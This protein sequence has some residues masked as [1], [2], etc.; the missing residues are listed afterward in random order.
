M[1]KLLFILIIFVM[2]IPVCVRAEGETVVINSITLEEKTGRAVEFADPSVDGLT[3]NYDVRFKDVNDSVK[4]VINITNNDNESLFIRDNINSVG[5]NIKYEIDF[6]ED[7]LLPG[8][9]RDIVLKIT[10]DKKVNNSDFKGGLYRNNN[11]IKLSLKDKQTLLLEVSNTLADSVVKPVLMV[12]AVVLIVFMINIIWKNKKANTLLILF[13]LLLIPKETGALKTFVIDINNKVA[14]EFKPC[15]TETNTLR[16]GQYLY[17]NSSSGWSVILYDKGLTDPVTTPLCSSVND[18]PITSMAY[19]FGESKTTSVDTST[20]DTSH[21]KTMY[22]MFYK[23]ANIE[24][25]DLSTFDTSNVTDMNSMFDQMTNV[26]SINIDSFDTRNVTSFVNMFRFNS[27]L[28]ELDTS[29]IVVSKPAS[30]AYVYAYDTKLKKIDL[31]N[32]DIKIQNS[33]PFGVMAGATGVE[34]VDMSNWDLSGKSAMNLLG[35]VLGGSSYSLNG[36]DYG[37]TFIIKKVILKN[38]NFSNVDMSY[39]FGYAPSIEEFDLENVN[40]TGVTNMNGL[41]SGDK[42]LKSIDLSSFDVSEVTNMSYM[43]DSN[44]ALKNIDLSGLNP[45]KV[46][47]MY[48]MFMK[49]TSLEN[50]NLSNFEAPLLTDMGYFLYGSSAIE[51]VDLSS[52]KPNAIHAM[53]N[54][55]NGA[56]SVKKLNISNFNF[57]DYGYSNTNILGNMAAPQTLEELYMENS[58]LTKLSFTSFTYNYKSLTKVS[59]KNSD[60]T[61]ITNFTNFMSYIPTLTSLDI[62]GVKT[63]D[64]TDFTMAFSQLENLEELDVSDLDTDSATTFYNMFFGNFKIKEYDVSK[65]KTS[66]VT[67]LYGMFSNNYLLESMDFSG[68]N[69]SSLGTAQWILG[70]C[71]KLKSVSFKGWDF[72]RIEDYDMF[73]RIIGGSSYALSTSSYPELK[74]LDLT[75][76]KFNGTYDGARMFGDMDCIENLLIDNISITNVTNARGF[77]EGTKSIKKLDLSKWVSNEVTSLESAF[78]SMDLLEELDISGLDLS[79]VTTFSH[80]FDYSPNLNK[81]YVKSAADKTILENAINNSNI[82]V[83]VK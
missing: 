3:I 25:L 63:Q 49:T 66:H 2:F 58:V 36:V 72:S 39:A 42:A 17:S 55:L 15:T 78:Q 27:N 73:G 11:Q 51:N 68:W 75:N 32:W 38:A 19:M 9:S 6:G 45:A 70:G 4:Y 48:G 62:T 69:T 61:G 21:V 20:F 56:T 23:A 44:I 18:Q 79:S 13:V 16:D 53:N 26:R 24:E 47:T 67:S 28:E 65:F 29:K 5:N 8:D 37:E 40:T 14:V 57:S 71:K 80:I 82:S 43:F 7:E 10:Y 30:L 60:F 33:R 34:E 74:K 83:I 81:V 54:M 35:Q 22:S 52:L 77:F 31:S 76:T 41:F 46:T 50:L 64:V 1:K 12:I 59:F